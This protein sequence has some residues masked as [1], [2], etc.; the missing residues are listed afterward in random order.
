MVILT[1]KI[2]LLWNKILLQL[3][4]SGTIQSLW[5][6]FKDNFFFS[7]SAMYC[8]VEEGNFER[9]SNFEQKKGF[10]C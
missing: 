6:N 4:P 7:I 2:E 5:A 9:V 1:A 10:L 3:V 8:T